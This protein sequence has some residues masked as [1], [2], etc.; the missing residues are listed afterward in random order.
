M[1]RPRTAQELIHWL[2]VGGGAR[3]LRLAAV[4][5]VTLALSLRVAWT[6]FHGPGSEATLIQAD[7]GRQLAQGAGFT[8][9]VNF[10]Q[11]AAVL[12]ARG[13][14]F[15]PGRPYPELHHAPLYPLVIAGALRVLPSRWREAWMVTAPVP[16]DGFAPDY[17]LLGLNLVLLWLAAGLTYVLGRRLFEPR[18]GALAAGAVLLSVSIWRETVAVNG[19]PLLMVLALGAFLVWHRIEEGAATA[20]P[21]VRLALWPA[22]L[23]LCGALLFLAEYAAGTLVLVA[24]AYAFFRF[25]GGRR[26]LV[27]AGVAGGFAVG[28]V[29]WVLRNVILTGHPV[30]LAGHNVALKA[31]DSTAEPVTMRATLSAVGPRI[32]L[33]KLANK[34]LSTLQED[35]KSRIWSGGA[36]WF[37]AFLSPDGCMPFA[38]RPRTACAGFSRRPLVCC[39]WPRRR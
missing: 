31:G 33:K 21:G 15:D 14:R 2:E 12:E 4:L 5:A 6:Q 22:A 19:T 37:S 35:L 24:L 3:W 38:R 16:P 17:V 11:T 25:Q 9:L 32:D 36:M 10:P 13:L 28:A 23:G 7:T 29:P 18:V 27:M 34:T 20:A 8:T 30:A 1:S 26:W 39:C